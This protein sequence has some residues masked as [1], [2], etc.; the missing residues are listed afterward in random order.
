MT[1]KK[2]YFLSISFIILVAISVIIFLAIH[3]NTKTQLTN[4]S[5]KQIDTIIRHDLQQGHIPG[6]S[7]LIIKNGKVFLNKGYGYQNIDKKINQHHQQSM[8]LLLIQKHLQV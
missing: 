1:I 8:K 2:L 7:V 3:S 4:D 5:Q 6:A